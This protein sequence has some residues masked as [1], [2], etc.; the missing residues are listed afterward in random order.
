MGQQ[1]SHS[2]IQ[3]LST[4][5]QLYIARFLNV[6]C[7][8]DLRS[9][10][11]TCSYYQSL[12]ASLL[13]WRVKLQNTLKV[14]NSIKAISDSPN[15]VYLKELH[16]AGTV[17]CKAEKEEVA[18][19]LPDVVHETLSNL[20]RFPNLQ[21]VRVEFPFG[22]D[23]KDGDYGVTI[24]EKEESEEVVAS[25]ERNERWR[26]LM[27]KTFH[28]LANNKELCFRKFEIKQLIAKEVSTFNS[29]AFHEFLGRV[30][31][32]KLSMRGEESEMGVKMNV[33]SGF[34]AFVSRL[35]RFF[36]NHLTSVT[37]LAIV[38]DQAGP[39]GLEGTRH[40]RLALHKHQMPLL[41]TIYL[42]NIFICPE[43]V[44]FLLARTPTMESI[45]LHNCFAS[46]QGSAKTGIY[47]SE[48]FTALHDAMPK[49]LCHLEIT[50]MD[51]PL[52]IQED[53][54]GPVRKEEMPEEY[55]EARQA[56]EENLRLRLFPYASLDET[57][58]E[59]LND[60]DENLDACLRGDDQRAYDDL[61]KIV[62]VNRKPSGLPAITC[63]K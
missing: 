48:F 40:V 45:S 24:F 7:D 22:F 61:M 16:F 21:F 60:Y 38:A 57:Y 28:A 26:A 29:E 35:D 2:P 30:K 47:W 31:Q 55:F 50:P 53:G 14:G 8:A 44:S 4:E 3:G 20:D 23:D 46:M 34:A 19:V 15:R 12:F 37:D 18:A 32:F 56:L 13:S 33:L 36:F 1:D 54:W 41:K 49:K 27:A 63:S 43:L 52:C 5:L 25:A 59:I 6:G 11:L 62:N 58:G 10:S 17:S 51:V 39:L 42:E 9:W